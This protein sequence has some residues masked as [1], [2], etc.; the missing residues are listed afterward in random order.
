MTSATA[1]EPG[2]TPRAG[3]VTPARAPGAGK[4]KP[5]RIPGAGKGPLDRAL[6]VGELARA[7]GLTV[8][9]LHHYDRLG[10]LKPS[11]RS[12]LSCAAPLIPGAKLAARRVRENIKQNCQAE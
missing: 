1:Q 5:A 6:A 3:N 11:G 8:R 4:A 10:L 2:R 12:G 9:T 7:T